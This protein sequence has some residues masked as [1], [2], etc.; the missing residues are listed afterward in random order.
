MQWGARCAEQCEKPA[1]SAVGLGEWQELR[2][3][4]PEWSGKG[5]LGGGTSVQGHAKLLHSSAGQPGALVGLGEQ[6]E[7]QVLVLRIQACR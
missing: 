2:I 1:G 6:R 3:P 4:D 5:H 7:L